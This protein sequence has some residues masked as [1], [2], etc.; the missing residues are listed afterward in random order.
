MLFAIFIATPLMVERLSFYQKY[1]FIEFEHKGSFREVVLSLA[2]V[3]ILAM[4]FR[5][6]PNP[7][8]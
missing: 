1:F 8:S 6:G 5:T 2:K 3:E 7:H 4:T